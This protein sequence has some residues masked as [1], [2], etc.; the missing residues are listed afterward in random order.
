M[1]V[2]EENEEVQMD[3]EEEDGGEEEGLIASVVVVMVASCSSEG[4]ASI[5]ACVSVS[6]SAF[7]CSKLRLPG[8]TLISAFVTA[9]PFG[10][11][12]VVV[13]CIIAMAVAILAKLV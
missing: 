1:A 11:S 6:I 3:E 4:S 10:E 8:E 9:A 7:S 13:V 2:E 12:S 5:H